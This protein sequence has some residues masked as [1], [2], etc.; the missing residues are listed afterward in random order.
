MKFRP[1]EDFFVLRGSRSEGNA[2][3]KAPRSSLQASSSYFGK[4]LLLGRVGLSLHMQRSHHAEERI[5][6]MYWH[7]E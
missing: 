4:E 6:T 1:V 3:R 2:T 5:C 7:K